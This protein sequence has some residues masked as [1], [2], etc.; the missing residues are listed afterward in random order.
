M[1]LQAPLVCMERHTPAQPEALAHYAHG[2][3]LASLGV[4]GAGR[5]RPD[6]EHG[7]TDVERSETQ[8][9]RREFLE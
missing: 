7:P 4:Q 9:Q 3:G 2:M 5:A 6:G 8:L 1:A